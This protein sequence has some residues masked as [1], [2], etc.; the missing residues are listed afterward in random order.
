MKFN[1]VDEITYVYKEIRRIKIDPKIIYSLEIFD[2]NY[3]EKKIKWLENG[4]PFFIR[5]DL[6]N[7]LIISHYGK[8]NKFK[9]HYDDLKSLII[10]IQTLDKNAN[11]EIFCCHPGIAKRREKEFSKFIKIKTENITAFK[12]IKHKNE[13]ILQLSKV[14]LIIHGKKHYGKNKK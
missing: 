12:I 10:I 7:Y 1:T 5:M 11:I 13:R 3:K 8:K 9:T 2:S 4:I 6:H 14:I